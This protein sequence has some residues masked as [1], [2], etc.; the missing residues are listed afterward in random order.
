MSAPSGGLAFWRDLLAQVQL[1]VLGD[2]AGRAALLQPALSLQQLGRLLLAEPPLA[3]D[4]ILMAARLPRLQGEVQGLQHALS[5]LGIDRVQQLART[6]MNRLFSDERPAHRGALQ[7]MSTSRLAAALVEHWDRA[8]PGGSGEYLQWVAMILGL[9][10]WKLPLAAPEV[11]LQIERRARA[12]EHRACVERELLGCDTNALNG[13]LLAAAGLSTDPLLTEAMTPD[14]RLLAEAAHHAWTGS[15]APALP[16][17]LSRRLRSRT[18]LAVLAHLLAWSA[19]DGWYS[20]RTL[21]LMRAA[22]A[23]LHQPLDRVI[24][25][26]HQV[27]VRASRAPV[28][29]GRVFTP[30]Q[31]LFWPP[32]VRHTPAALRVAAARRAG[33]SHEPAAPARAA[34]ARPPDVD[35]FSD[36]TPAAP[37]R[38]AEAPAADPAIVDAFV[39]DCR[40]GAHRDLRSFMAALVR[41]L[42]QGIGLRRCL[43]MLKASNADRLVCCFAHGFD[44]APPARSLAGSSADDNLLARLYQRPGSA[45]HVAAARVPVARRQLP[46]ALAPLAPTGGFLVGSLQAAERPLG[47]MWADRGNG[48]DAPAEHHYAQFRHMI[49]HLGDEFRRLAGVSSGA[50]RG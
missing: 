40:A 47:V 25:D 1:P 42:E 11:H 6:R 27:A 8:N 39:R 28:L 23:L 14:P 4:T 5:V 16:T 45:L 29:G 10:R 12:G 36:L 24:A 26:A 44:P 19:C 37:A 22:S 46:P 43:L 41:T 32:A 49:R 18:M 13:A 15:I 2:E 9:A 38:R 21:A 17:D 31:Q 50:R 34:A 33:P 48:S 35:L 3:L 30:A 20:R 7:A